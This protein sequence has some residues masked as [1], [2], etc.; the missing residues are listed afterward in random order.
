L[1]GTIFFAAFAA[2]LL[3]AAGQDV[4]QRRISNLFPLLLVALFL[5]LA[6][7]RGASPTLFQHLASFAVM[8]TAGA[9]L[10][11]RGILG[12]GD[13]KL[14]AAVALWFQVSLLPALIVAITLC[15]GVLAFIAIARRLFLPVRAGGA[16]GARRRA[17]SVPYGLAIAL[18]AIAVGWH[19][20]PEF[21]AT[22]TRFVPMS[23]LMAPLE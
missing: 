8:F 12:G 4:W 9:L 20:M 6:V 11:S 16:G 10:F 1:T 3:A 21:T 14:I 22:E 5:A 13:A 15:G 18:G 17:S 19:A 2:V 7:W 23:E